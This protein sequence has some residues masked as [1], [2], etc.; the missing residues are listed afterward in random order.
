MPYKIRVTQNKSQSD[1]KQ[2]K[3]IRDLRSENQKLRKENARLRKELTKRTFTEPE[4]VFEA[5]LAKV[6]AKTACPQCGSE[7]LTTLDLGVK[8][9]TVCKSCKW[10]KANK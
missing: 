2:A 8:I 1:K 5:P 4:E 6:T 9:L 10:R 3:E 7:E